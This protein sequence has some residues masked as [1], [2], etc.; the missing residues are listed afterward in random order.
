MPVPRPL[1]ILACAIV[2]TAA[3]RIH[4]EESGAERSWDFSASLYGYDVPDSEDFWNPN[5]TADHGRLHLEARTNYEA[6]SSTSLWAGANFSAGTSWEFHATAML[7]GVFGSLEGVAPGYR[8]SLGHEWF[9]LA[10][11]GEYFIGVHAEDGNYL[12]SWTEAAGSPV[13][14]FRAGLAV[15]RTREYASDLTIQRGAFVG[16]TVKRFDVAAYVFNLSWEDPTYV[17]ALRLEF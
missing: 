3:F 4:A 8:L 17:L 16:F 15:Q 6:V 13:H 2:V 1:R 11:E 9:S 12:Y 10:S 5:L 7:G 14:W